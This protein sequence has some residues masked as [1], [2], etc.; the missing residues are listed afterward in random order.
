MHRNSNGHVLHPQATCYT[1]GHS[2]NP[3]TTT[4]MPDASSEKGRI[5]PTFAQFAHLD[6]A[7]RKT[8][9]RAY[10]KAVGPD[11]PGPDLGEGPGS[12]DSHHGH[13]RP[14]TPARSHKRK[15]RESEGTKSHKK[16]A[17]EHVQ[18]VQVW[19]EREREQSPAE[20]AEEG[21]EEGKHE[22]ED[23]DN[24][25]YDGY[26]SG[27]ITVAPG[28]PL[29]PRSQRHH[30]KQYE[31]TTPPRSQPPPPLSPHHPASLSDYD[32][33]HRHFPPEI[34]T[35]RELSKQKTVI[36]GYPISLLT[37]PTR[38]WMP[39]LDKESLI[40][41]GIREVMTTCGLPNAVP[42]IARRLSWIGKGK[43][44]HPRPQ[45][46]RLGKFTKQR[47]RS[48]TDKIPAPPGPPASITPSSNDRASN[49]PN[50]EGVEEWSLEKEQRKL[51]GGIIDL[52]TV[53]D[54]IDRARANSL[55]KHSIVGRPDE[56]V[57]VDVPLEV[58]LAG[59]ESI[60]FTDLGFYRIYVPEKNQP[61]PLREQQNKP[62][63]LNWDLEASKIEVERDRRGGRQAPWS[64][65]FLGY[66]WESVR[67]ELLDA[68]DAEEGESREWVTTMAGYR[69]V[70]GKEEVSHNHP[71]AVGSGKSPGEGHVA[72][73]SHPWGRDVIE[74]PPV[75]VYAEGEYEDV[76][77]NWFP[78][79]WELVKE[80]GGDGED[81][82]G[83]GHGGSGIGGKSG[84]KGKT[85]GGGYM[86]EEAQGE[87]GSPVRKRDRV[88]S[89]REKGSVPKRAKH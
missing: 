3:T 80:L 56:F 1:D 6:G 45:R 9:N 67:M 88:G 60:A 32:S 82:G 85:H 55:I 4:V 46:N 63:R 21:D 39:I 18:L 12:P 2:S 33:D 19:R 28:P 70:R 62:S 58:L 41:Q 20:A 17:A 73:S 53:I 47:D 49:P 34:H 54:G 68:G 8:R 15:V 38:N 44:V 24:G 10:Q 13:G 40:H 74:P 30:K 22:D 27:T 83:S 78:W 50:T 5:S 26:D 72:A 65:T 76:V 25:D 36:Y 11:G 89:F 87:Q 86:K 84:G 31:P 42:M 61:F 52:G 57:D 23:D 43:V 16:K 37:S 51:L 79:A 69:I 64:V 7:V 59:T 77:R 81:D 35:A 66:E 29:V 48:G 14:P 71:S 75:G